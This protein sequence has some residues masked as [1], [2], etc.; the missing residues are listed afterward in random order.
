MT[1]E[2]VRRYRFCSTMLK[3]KACSVGVEVPVRSQNHVIK[4]SGGINILSRVVPCWL[5]KFRYF[6][7]L[8]LV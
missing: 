4:Q 8:S 7:P 2:R 3:E 5:V 1:A 6:W